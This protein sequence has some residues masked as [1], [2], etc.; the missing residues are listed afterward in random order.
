VP[1]Q[2]AASAETASRPA[3]VH[4]EGVA[5]DGFT[6]WISPFAANASTP[7]ASVEDDA[8]YSN[9]LGFRT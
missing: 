7:G 4:D 2:P 6:T 3:A 9:Y 5:P 8:P 1:R